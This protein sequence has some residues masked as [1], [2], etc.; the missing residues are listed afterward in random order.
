MFEQLLGQYRRP[1]LNFVRRLIGDAAEA[2]DVAQ[3]VF[4]RAYRH[5]GEY[6]ASRKFSTWLFAMARNAAID[7]LR[8]RARR[9]TEPLEA[10]GPVADAASVSGEVVARETERRVAAAVAALPEEQRTVVVLSVYQGLSHAEIAAV[11]EV[12][13]KSVES[14]LYRARAVLRERLGDLL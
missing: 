7:R 2:E 11:M 12:S 8:H 5:F 3:E 6:D 1:V 13:E 9:A 4:V 10:A 14:R